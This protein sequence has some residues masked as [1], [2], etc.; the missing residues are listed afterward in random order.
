M[1]RQWPRI[2]PRPLCGRPQ[3]TYRASEL[4]QWIEEKSGGAIP[5]SAVVSISLEAL[6]ARDVDGIADQLLW[7]RDFGKIVVNATQESDLQV[8]VVAL[9]R[10]MAAGKCFGFRSAASWVP[11]LAGVSSAPVL[12]PDALRAA[13]RQGCGP[14]LIV[15][16]SWVAKTTRQLE[17]LRAHAPELSWVEVDAARAQNPAESAPEIRRA[18]EEIVRNWQQGRPACVFSSRNYRADTPDASALVAAALVAIVSGALH[19]AAPPP[20]WIIAKGGITSSDIATR[21]LGARRAWVLG[22]I[23]QGVPLWQR[24]EQSAFAGGQYVVFP[25]NVG[26]D[27]TLTEVYRALES[28]RLTQ[29]PGQSHE[30]F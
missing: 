25:G 17:H 3:S 5:A 16:G 4:P 22:P 13:A 7:V 28:G 23:A 30:D 14:G 27:E 18:Q 9:A 15:A 21:A 1:T 12:S 6:R 11:T 20:A 19:D 29:N 10:A 26:G 24:G 8:F 2:Y